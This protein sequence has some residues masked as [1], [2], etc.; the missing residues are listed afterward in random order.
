VEMMNNKMFLDKKSIFELKL[1]NVY[2][3]INGVVEKGFEII[4]IDKV[5]LMEPLS[6]FNSSNTKKIS[7]FLSDI[8]SSGFAQ[9]IGK[10]ISDPLLYP[11]L[12]RVIYIDDKIKIYK[13]YINNLGNLVASVEEINKDN[14]P[15]PSDNDVDYIRSKSELLDYFDAKIV[16]VK[17]LDIKLARIGFSDDFKKFLKEQKEKNE[18]VN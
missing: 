12:E 10:R 6:V 2:D 1:A 5:A 17:K 8:F 13:L 16:P 3:P 18:T 15:E 4:N 7:V 14:H 11:L 9:A